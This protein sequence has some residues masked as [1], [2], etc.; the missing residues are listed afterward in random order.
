MNAPKGFVAMPTAEFLRG[1]EDPDVHAENECRQIGDTH[2]CA[3]AEVSLGHAGEHA[4]NDT[5]VG[6]LFLTRRGGEHGLSFPL[7]SKAMRSLSGA[8]LHMADMVDAN[9]SSKAADL[10]QRAKGAGK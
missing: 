9:A 7:T 6:L 4:E 3:A 1:D 8:L 10:I 2:F 5:G